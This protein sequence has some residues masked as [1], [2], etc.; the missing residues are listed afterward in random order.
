M[1]LS[2]P[3]SPR[4]PSRTFPQQGDS[5]AEL[6]PISTML[7][8]VDESDED[9][10]APNT[11]PLAGTLPIAMKHSRRRVSVDVGGPQ[12]RRR[13]AAPPPSCIDA[14]YRDSLQPS[15]YDAMKYLAPDKIITVDTLQNRL[16]RWSPENLHWNPIR[17]GST[18]SCDVLANL[19]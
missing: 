16:E 4:S 15:A 18:R 19:K 10:P 17:R 8:D 5:S 12:R 11:F 14:F 2:S 6:P 13:I 9:A 1:A 7:L 3:D